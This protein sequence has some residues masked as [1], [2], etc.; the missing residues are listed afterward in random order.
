ML[1]PRFFGIFAPLFIVLLIGSLI[2][3]CT[4][5]P[6]ATENEFEGA[7]KVHRGL[8]P[9]TS[10]SEN[11][12]TI[13]KSMNSKSPN[14]LEEI[15]HI[16]PQSQT[17]NPSISQDTMKFKGCML[18]LNFQGQLNV[19][20]NSTISGYTTS[21][22][23]QHDRITVTDTSNTVVWYIKN[24][25]FGY[26]SDAHIQDPEWSTHPDYLACL[27]DTKEGYLDNHYSIF[28]VH[29]LSRRVYRLCEKDVGAV[30]T[31]HLW[32]EQGHTGG[33][34]DTMTYSDSLDDFA[35][36]SCIE[37]IFGTRKVKIVYHNRASNSQIECIDYSSSPP[38]TFTLKKPE[39]RETWW[40]ESPLISPG[41]DWVTYSCAERANGSVYEAY[42]Q[43]LSP[44]SEPVLI[45]SSGS[46]PHW[47]VNPSSGSPYIIYTSIPGHYLVTAIPSF[48]N[49]LNGEHGS[50]LRV[51]VD[52][53]AMGRA[54]IQSR[55]AETIAG[56]PFKGGL[57]PDG[58]Y[59]ATG[60]Q[61]T[62]MASLASSSGTSTVN[63]I[64]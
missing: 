28:S 58:K 64:P 31:P 12:S 62:Y 19:N 51:P 46:A 41:G 32:I 40:T 2:I 36:P 53:D 47:W 6:N 55:E 59:L 48:E 23:P 7:E 17:C 60:Y 54:Q 1:F 42:L 10:T 39:G 25:E 52:L 50:T 13:S 57:S 24:S 22:V 9:T 33:L 63:S 5:T 61:F 15:F 56:F 45:S 21:G 27:L 49:G 37:D 8:S 29:M 14:H 44:N 43:H 20:V 11:P 38:S 4:E 3:G 26:S 16:N 34:A 30:A 18:W 35:A